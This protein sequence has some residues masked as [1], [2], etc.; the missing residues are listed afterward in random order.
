[1]RHF[2]NQSSRPLASTLKSL[3]QN[4]VTSTS[5]E[6]STLSTSLDDPSS[7]KLVV[8]DWVDA[9][10]TGGSEWQTTEDISE[11]VESGP[12][13]VRTAGLLLENNDSYVAVIDTIILDGEAGGYVHVIP[14]G[15]I[16]RMTVYG[17][18][19]GK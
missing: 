12:S 11:A 1:M 14:R 15:M 8:I 5:A 13:M 2:R 17:D 7:L 9:V 4:E 6:S 3:Y 18:P 10:C 19:H 16:K